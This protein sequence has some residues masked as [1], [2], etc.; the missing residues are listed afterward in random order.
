M[1]KKIEEDF[2]AIAKHRKN[3]VLRDSQVDLSQH[4]L[5]F[6]NRCDPDKTYFTDMQ[7]FP[8]SLI[9]EAGTGTGKS[10]AYL[11]PIVRSGK[12]AIISTNTKA[13]QK[14]LSSELKDIQKTNSMMTYKILQG[15]SNY[16]CLLRADG[17]V[18]PAITNW[19]N[20]QIREKKS[21]MI[22][23]FKQKS[24]KFNKMLWSLIETDPQL[25]QNSCPQFGRCFYQTAKK[26]AHMSEIVVMNHDLL[27]LH[28]RLETELFK[29]SQIIVID[30]AHHFPE[31]TR[32]N[33]SH[34][35]TNSSTSK[36]IKNINWKCNYIHSLDFTLD[37]NVYEAF[38]E[39]LFD[40]FPADIINTI[41]LKEIHPEAIQV[42]TRM[43]SQLQE[44]IAL[45][46][47]DCRKEF[48]ASDARKLEETLASIQQIFLT[49]NANNPNWA[50]VYNVKEGK[51]KSKTQ[52]IESL[53]LDISPLLKRLFNTK[54]IVMTSATLKSGNNFNFLKS[55]IG[56]KDAA[57]VSYPSPFDRKNVAMFIPKEIIDPNQPAYHQK[58]ASYMTDIHKKMG[59]KSLFLFT[60]KEDLEACKNMLPHESRDQFFIQ[61]HT[62]EVPDM[63]R[64]LQ[65]NDN[66]SLVGLS[67]LWE[68][69]DV[70]GKALSCVCVMRMPFNNPEDVIFSALKEKYKIDHNGEDYGFFEEYDL[71]QMLLKLKQGFGRLVR[72]ETDTGLIVLLDN[73]FMRKKYRDKVIE[74]LSNYNCYMDLDEAIQN[75]P[76]IAFGRFSR[77]SQTI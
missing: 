3:F 5:D 7:T 22:D 9:A 77:I 76:D 28:Y 36:L 12:K 6:V 70:V 33:L 55:Q 13:L 68:G 44:D 15:A 24:S 59:G 40:Y 57:S 65:S 30:E 10:L 31:K 62:S 47:Q 43:C 74:L 1:S 60:N 17:L 4:V 49:N 48:T 41:R 19:I 67:S 63:I 56:Q 37:A 2:I 21:G 34:K 69:I 23:E 75:I 29:K 26:D 27:L 61:S 71:P 64:K 42:A 35:I 14:Q 58:I 39:E 46:N 25:C 11:L 54:S 66:I 53:P 20:Q 52:T 72:H 51:K 50:K 18:M 8:S 73:R 32:Q 45:L 16:A 38:E